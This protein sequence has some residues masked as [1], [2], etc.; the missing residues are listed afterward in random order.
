MI[1]R[2]NEYSVGNESVIMYKKM[3]ANRNINI[4]IFKSFCPIC[5]EKI[6]QP[7]IEENTKVDSIVKDTFFEY[8]SIHDKCLKNL[9]KCSDTNCTYFFN[10]NLYHKTTCNSCN[11]I[12]CHS[13]KFNKQCFWCYNFRNTFILWTIKKS[14]PKLYQIEDILKIII[15]YGRFPKS[16]FH[17][18]VPF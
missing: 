3:S 9:T 14:C 8:Y 6:E 7:N 11:K 12:T 4:Y 1:F 18:Y 10:K 5:R 15:D 13:H 16:M 2:K 17:I